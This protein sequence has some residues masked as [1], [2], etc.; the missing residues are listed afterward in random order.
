M[1]TYSDKDF[2]KDLIINQIICFRS[3]IKHITNPELVSTR[4]YILVVVATDPRFG[5]HSNLAGVC[6]PL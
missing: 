6:F 1:R 4:L 3:H 5:R 2:N